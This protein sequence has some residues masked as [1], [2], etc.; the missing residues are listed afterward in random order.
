[1]GIVVSALLVLSMIAGILLM[2]N[3]IY[4]KRYLTMEALT[5]LAFLV[6]D[7]YYCYKAFL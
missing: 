1:M 5:V 3:I 4:R 2:G 6:Y 7:G